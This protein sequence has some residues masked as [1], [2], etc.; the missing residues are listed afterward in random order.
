MAYEKTQKQLIFDPMF[1]GDIR[2]T[3]ANNPPEGS[4]AKDFSIVEQPE[5]GV[6][7]YRAGKEAQ[8]LEALFIAVGRA[9]QEAKRK[10]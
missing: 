9:W 1:A 2:D 10:N 8:A 6:L 3:C 4:T 7:V 5:C